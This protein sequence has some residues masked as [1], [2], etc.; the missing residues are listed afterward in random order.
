[1]SL[2]SFEAFLTTTAFWQQGPQNGGKEGGS[3]DA[4]T[5]QSSSKPIKF[6]W[7]L[8]SF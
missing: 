7:L 2:Q 4:Q 1:M 3:Q 8:A 5:A 6:P